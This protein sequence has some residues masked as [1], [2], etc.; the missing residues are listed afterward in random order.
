M[1]IWDI[2]GTT[3]ITFNRDRPNSLVCSYIALVASEKCRRSTSTGA[4]FVPVTAQSGLSIS[5]ACTK[6]KH[7]IAQITIH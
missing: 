1:W 5:Y 3:S 7:G 2:T 6:W 4:F